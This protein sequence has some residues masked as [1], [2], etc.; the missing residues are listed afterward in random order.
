MKFKPIIFATGLLLATTS[1]ED[2]LTPQNK[3]A[4]EAGKQLGTEAGIENA[5]ND[6]YYSLRAIYANSNYTNWFQAG[7]DMY[8]SARNT[9]DADYQ[10]YTITPLNSDN[11]DLYTKCYNGIRSAYAVAHYSTG[12]ANALKRVDEARVIA[13]NYYYLLVNSYGGVPLIKSFVN[14]AETG[15]ARASAKETYEYII[16]EL[17]NVIANNRLDA[18]NATKGGGRV[19]MEAAKALLAKTYLAA[20]WDLDN[21]TYFEKAAGYADQVI[22]GQ[23][24]LTTQYAKL[25]AADGSGD[26]NA[27]FIW[28]VE[29]NKTVAND[30]TAGGH[31]MHTWYWNYMG[32]QEDRGKY[33]MSSFVPTLYTLYCFQKDDERYDAT[34]MKELPNI[35]KAEA[36]GD[37]WDYY[38]NGGSY[39]KT[40]IQRYYA[41]WYETPA[42]IAAWRAGS[43][44]RANAYVIEMAEQTHEA[45][46]MDGTPRTYYNMIK[47]VYGG[48]P[49]KKFDDSNNPSSGPGNTDYRDIHILTLPDMYLVAAEAY[50][51]LGNTTKALERVN[52]VRSR[53]KAPLRT[54]VSLNDILDERALELYGMD[55]RW[56]DLRRTRTLKTRYEQY[57]PQAVKDQCKAIRP[58]PQSALDANKLLTQN[59]EYTTAR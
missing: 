50:L 23:S 18:K 54:T 49:V 16:A 19:S 31:D 2:F 9:I 35:N 27:E 29:Y 1:C 51:K 37:Y 3:S 39:G 8:C 7:T 30:K 41:A 12:S 21:N 36:G 20:A 6:A 33:G 47:D 34:F 45:Q 26:D 57:S 24:G 28:D 32:G 13:A 11:A 5:V 10:Q 22:T 38:A 15:Y 55:A 42:D 58:I 14:K 43:A 46:I 48:A 4:L 53:A 56:Y 59:K 52:A 44:T 40:P 25:Y 17:E